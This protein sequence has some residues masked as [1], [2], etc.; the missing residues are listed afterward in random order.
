M[1]KT[2]LIFL[3]CA[4]LLLTVTVNSSADSFEATDCTPSPTD[5][6]KEEAVSTAIASL[7][8][9]FELEDL[10]K[11]DCEARFV[12]YIDLNG[13]VDGEPQWEIAIGRCRVVLDRHGKPVMVNG[14]GRDIPWESDTLAVSVPVDPVPGDGTEEEAIAKAWEA[15]SDGQTPWGDERSGVEA[16][17]ELIRNEHFCG[18]SDPV[19]L[20]T[21][22][23]GNP[24]YKVLLR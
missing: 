1:K 17:A 8:E 16:R 5:T 18:N 7:Y 9:R 20:V 22:L 3:S 2:I 10:E 12:T 11:Q 21:F 6:Q 19:W 23:K 13:N 24:C 15:V 14:G 4:L